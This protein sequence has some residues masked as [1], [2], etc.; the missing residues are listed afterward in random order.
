M[1]V[2]V[3]EKYIPLIEECGTLSTYRENE[4]IYMQEES[5]D[6]IYFV[7][8]GRGRIFL[9]MENGKELTFEIIRKGRIFGDAS[10]LS[11][12]IRQV[13]VQA[14]TDMQVIHCSSEKIME[15]M[16]EE[17]EFMRLILRHMTD[18][19]NDLLHQLI[20]SMQYDSEQK[21]ADYL[22]SSTSPEHPVM[23]FSHEDLAAC[24]GMNRVT[25]TRIL[26]GFK[27]KQYIQGGYGMITVLDRAGLNRCLPQKQR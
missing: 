16:S 19:C 14:V 3:D 17:P 24:L 7:R 12:T 23:S 4:L 26:Q 1:A 10:F 20:R 2:Y 22:L 27:E 25:V 6:N 13:S 8:S 9:T 11:H 18:S 15:V 5:A 21:L